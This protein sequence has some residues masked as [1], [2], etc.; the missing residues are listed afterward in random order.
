MFDH[1]DFQITTACTQ[2]CVHCCLDIPNK[3]HAHVPLEDIK[4]A[5]MLINPVFQVQ[6][7]G[8]EPTL[9]PELDAISASFKE[10]VGCEEFNIITNGSTKDWVPF[11]DIFNRF[12]EVRIT[13][14]DSNTYDGC[15]YNNLE[16]IKSLCALLPKERVNIV[17]SIHIP[18]SRRGSGAICNKGTNN[19]AIYAGGLMWPCCAASGV[20]GG[21]GIPVTKNWKNELVNVPKPCANCWFSP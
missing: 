15:P 10:W 11:V 21:I 9:H 19:T 2:K 7:T 14:Y 16:N 17:R 13:Q 20:D 1:I 6:L 18:R 5:A 8:G 4:R 3:T 12:R